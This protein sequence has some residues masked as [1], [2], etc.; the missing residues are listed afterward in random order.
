M[1]KQHDTEN[2]T[3]KVARLIDST[4]RR[5]YVTADE[6]GGLHAVT[7]TTTDAAA[8]GRVHALLVQFLDAVDTSKWRY[9]LCITSRLLDIFKPGDDAGADLE[10]YEE[11]TTGIPFDKLQGVASELATYKKDGEWA[12]WSG[13]PY[14]AGPCASVVFYDS[15]C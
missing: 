6:D 9:S 1:K 15:W 3:N 12:W 5:L 8:S 11:A 10:G 13:A 14:E 2:T 7:Y 4:T